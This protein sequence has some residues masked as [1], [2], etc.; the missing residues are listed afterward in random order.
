MCV[1]EALES[2]IARLTG[3]GQTTRAQLRVRERRARTFAF[4][5]DR[6]TPN[7]PRR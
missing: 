5:D 2:S 4:D 6:A 3:A 7:N 1:V